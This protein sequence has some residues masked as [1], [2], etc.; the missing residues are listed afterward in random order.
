MPFSWRAGSGGQL[1]T[2]FYWPAGAGERLASLF[3]GCVE[4]G[5]SSASSGETRKISGE[6]ENIL[7]ASQRTAGGSA[8]ARSEVTF[9]GSGAAARESQGASPCSAGR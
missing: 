2:H 3:T 6:T 9:Q 8:A 7:C 5:G 1:A 4:P